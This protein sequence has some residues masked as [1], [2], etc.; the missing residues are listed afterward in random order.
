M[1]LPKEPRQKMINI[2]Y[3]VLTAMLALNVSAEILN[4]FKTVKTSLEH[5]S[6]AIEDKNVQI[7]KSFDQMLKDPTKALKANEW[8]PYAQKAKTLS[9][10]AYKYIEALKMELMREAGYNP[11][12]DTAFKMDD[13][14]AATRLLVEQKKK[15]PELLKKLTDFKTQL[16]ALHPDITAEFKST[17]PIDLSIPVTQNKE[18]KT[19]EGAYFHMTPAIAALTILSKFQNDIR[20]SEVA[21]VEYCHKQVGEVE[22][23][24]DQFKAIANASASYVMPDEEIV[25]NAGVGAFSS[26]AKPSVTVDGSGT[27]ALPDG[28]YEYKFKAPTAAGEYTKKVRVSFVKPDGTTATVDKDIKYTVGQLAGLTVSTDATRVFYSGGLSNPLSVTGAGGSEKIQLSVDGPGITVEK[29]SGGNYAI[30]C[31]QPGTAIVKATDGK[32]TQEFKIPI[33]RV[34]DPVATVNGK[35]G[36]DMAAAT[37]RAAGGVAAKLK[38]FIFE[39]YSFKVVSFAM[40]FTGTGF[41]EKN[42]VVEVNGNAFNA[43]ARKFMGRCASGTTV[44]IGAIKVADQIGNVR[45]LDGNISFVLE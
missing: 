18:I 28:S 33:K 14:D 22:V 25:I 30:K 9:D 20:N 16:L 26:A 35:Q 34:P 29:L 10:D 36:G 41:E 24:Y 4:A 45:E 31:T 6:N 40:Y 19:W 32:T 5:S 8:Y 43:E 17:L 23:V 2:M 42:E 44:I 7:F 15:G 27:Q 13:L 37:F 3:L 11:P 21:V 39:G 1:A 12:K 38:D